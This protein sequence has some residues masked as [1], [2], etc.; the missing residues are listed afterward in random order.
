MVGLPDLSAY[1]GRWVALAD[2]AVAGVGQT[3]M[4]ALRWGRHNRPKETLVLWFVEPPGG[5]VLVL[6]PLLEQL[7]PFLVRQ[8]MP[9]YLVGGAVRDALLGQASHDLDFVVPEKA[10]SLAF[11]VADELGVPAYVLD[12]ERDTGRVVLPELATTLDFA[13]FRGADLLADLRDRDFTVNAIALPVSAQTTAGLIDPCGGQADLA[14][15]VLRMTHARVI[16]DDPLRALRAL[17]LAVTFGLRLAAET[18]SAVSAAADLLDQVST[19]R[20][21]DE[22]LRLLATAVPHEAIRQLDKYQLLRTVLPE[23]ADLAVIEQ[24]PPHHEPVL[25]HTLSVLAWLVQLETAVLDG[26]P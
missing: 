21:R 20:V 11:R 5:E 6:S 17:R 13:S 22:L 23:I 15:G 16:E 9:V 7:R 24:S 14:A 3:P 10:I 2:G 8:E 26:E 4:E 1:A 12:R 18:E 19:E 25:P